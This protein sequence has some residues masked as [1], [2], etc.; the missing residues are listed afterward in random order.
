M[1]RTS[2]FLFGLML[3]LWTVPAEA[4]LLFNTNATWNLLRGRAEASSPD[5]AAWRGL[6]FNDS[7]WTPAPSPFWFGDVLPGGTQLTDMAN[8][9]TTV[10]LRRTVVLNDLSNISGLRLGYHCDDGFVIWVN[11]VELYRYNAPA[12]NL[13]FNASASAAVTEPVQF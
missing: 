9:Y 5:T 12:G 10:Y 6:T 11:G 8:T 3:A 1:R 4:V 13:A 2:C 7:A